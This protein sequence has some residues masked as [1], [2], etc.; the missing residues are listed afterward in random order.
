MI[1][2]VISYIFSGGFTKLE[3][4]MTM[5]SN[6]ESLTVQVSRTAAGVPSGHNVSLI[7]TGVMIPSPLL[8]PTASASQVN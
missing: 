1:I 6:G 2:L 4:K 3:H 5:G 8:S 7:H